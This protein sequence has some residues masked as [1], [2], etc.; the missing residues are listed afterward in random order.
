PNKAWASTSDHPQIMDVGPI[1]TT[2][3]IIDTDKIFLKDKLVK[4]ACDTEGA[5]IHFTL[6]GSVPDQNS[7]LYSEPFVV[8]ESTTIRMRAFRGDQ[9]SLPAQA[10]INKTGMSK[11]LLPG[12]VEP[13]LSY[14]YIHGNFRMVNDFQTIKPVKTGIVPVFTI[15]PREK[16][17]YFAFDFEGFINIPKDGLYTIYLTT[18]DGGRLFIDDYLLIN[19]DGLHPLTEIYKPVALKAGFHPV[20][21]KYF[22]E[23]GTVESR[24][25]WPNGPKPNNRQ[26]IRAEAFKGT[27]PLAPSLKKGGGMS[28]GFPSERSP[29]L[30]QGGVGVGT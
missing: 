22:Q 20:S 1:V 7:R 25:L 14:R 10:E 5:E 29:S 23:G 13:G 12:E 27:H 17:Q 6:D 4:L 11:P 16:E 15:E 21:V 30:F 19:N 3:Y 2:P 26:T 9:K 24:S 18:N 8:N 28:S